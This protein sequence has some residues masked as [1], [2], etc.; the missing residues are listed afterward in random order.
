MKHRKLLLLNRVLALLALMMLTSCRPWFTRQVSGEILAV[1]GRP[2]GILQGKT[3]RLTERTV[4][5]PGMT[6]RVP[7]ESRIDL[8]LLPGILIELRPDTEVE[9]ERLRLSRDGDESIRPMIA[10]EATI[11]LLRGALFATVGRAPT[12]SGLRIETLVGTVIA[13]SGRA[14]MTAAEGQKLRIVSAR[15][16]VAFA[17]LEGAP[18]IK[19][20]PGYFAV[21]PG[22]SAAPQP[23]AESGAQAQKEVAETIKTERQL[24]QLERENQASFRRWRNR[25]V[26]P[27]EPGSGN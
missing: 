26:H 10:R 19:I 5:S 27:T 13:G 9:I 25:P 22:P 18:L 24:Q 15:G 3:I 17:P 11:R 14:F 4:I 1:E 2:E 23:A 6:I 16:I 8:L 12:R 7:P 20:N 21:L